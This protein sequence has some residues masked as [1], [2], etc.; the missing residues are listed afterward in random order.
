MISTSASG[1]GNVITDLE[2][3]YQTLLWTDLIQRYLQRQPLSA[4]DSAVLSVQVD[5][6]VAAAT[7]AMVTGFAGD[8]PSTEIDSMTTKCQNA[9]AQDLSDPLRPGFKRP[10]TDDEMT[11]LKQQVS[12]EVGAG[13]AHW[14]AGANP[15]PT[16]ATG[17]ANAID[18]MYGQAVALVYT[19]PSLAPDQMA[20][21][22]QQRDALS[23]AEKV[24]STQ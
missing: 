4:A 10:F 12:A 6:L 9:L 2:I 19:P 3:Q 24:S 14:R 15:I 16:A 8:V 1:Y 18:H 22:Q 23:N 7:T 21:M 13:I 5:E 11:A 20:Q 17:T